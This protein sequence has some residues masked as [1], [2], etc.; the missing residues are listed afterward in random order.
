MSMME[1]GKIYYREGFVQTGRAYFRLVVKGQGGHGSSP[2]TS[3]DAIVAGAH[4]VTTTDHC[5]KTL[6]SV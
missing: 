5:F 2:H 1:T 4:F 3:N 6:K